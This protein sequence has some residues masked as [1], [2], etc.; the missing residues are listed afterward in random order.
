MSYELVKKQ[1]WWQL[2]SIQS[3]GAMCLPVIMAGQIIYEKF[4]WNAALL[5]MGLGNLFLLGMGFF[6]ASLSVERPQSTVEHAVYS[7]GSRGRALFSG[8]MILSVLGWFGIQLNV[9]SLGLEQLLGKGIPPLY[10]NLGMGILLSG[11]MCLGMGAIKWLSNIC[12]PLLGLTLLYAVSSATGSIPSAELMTLSW[13]GGVSLV[14]GTNI[15][16][17][18]DL[19]TFFRHAKS[20]R[21]A[22]LCILVLYGLVVPCIEAAGIYLSAVTG[23]GSILTVLQGNHN[24][25]WMAWV[26]CFVLMS[27]WVTNNANLYSALTSSYSLSSR[28]GA[29]GR[30]LFLGAIGILVACFN[31]L[32]NIEVVLDMLGITI[33]GLGAMILSNYFLEKRGQTSRN[34][35]LSWSVGVGVGFLSMILNWK[36][37]GVAV[38]DAFIASF[39]MQIILKKKGSYETVNGK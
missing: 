28:G 34:P 9:M 4:G 21:D 3:G 36:G 1:S 17:V 33:G 13:L 8:L 19:P 31:P 32:G 7:F 5:G 35:L 15:A 30:T 23:S 22:R 14:I 11:V 12:A 27:G 6:L 24:W 38:F 29:L 18:I 39:A 16:A 37:T 2:L 20:T 26:S 10:L 25:L